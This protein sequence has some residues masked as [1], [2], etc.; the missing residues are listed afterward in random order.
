MNMPAAV[1]MKRGTR[2]CS[3]VAIQRTRFGPAIER[4]SKVSTLLTY[5]RET[6]RDRREIHPSQ[7][8][9][10]F[11]S[12]ATGRAVTPISEKDTAPRH[13]ASTWSPCTC[14]VQ[15]ASSPAASSALNLRFDALGG[16][17]SAGRVRAH[18]RGVRAHPSLARARL[19]PYGFGP[20]SHGRGAICRTALAAWRRLAAR[21]TTQRTGSRSPRCSPSGAASPYR[22]GAGTACLAQHCQHCRHRHRHRHRH[23]T[24]KSAG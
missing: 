4:V 6:Q 14:H 20:A 3:G 24:G 15:P 18:P 7:M 1:H 16:H 11:S 21:P 22:T 12:A 19:W 17:P 8:K 13:G 10:G 23:R 9:R 5:D 2:T